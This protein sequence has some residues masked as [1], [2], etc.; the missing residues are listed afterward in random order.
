MLSLRFQLILA[1][2]SPRRKQ[3]LEAL[4]CNFKVQ[5][6]HT[7]EII[8]SHIK[9]TQAAAY[10]AE[11]KALAFQAD[12]E[13]HQAVLAADTIVLANE[14]ILNK[15]ADAQ[16]AAVMLQMLSGNVHQVVTGVCLMTKQHIITHSDI[17]QVHFR[18]LTAQEIDYYI[19][20]YRPFDKAGAYGIQEWIGMI[21]ITKIE[22]SFFTVMGLPTHLVYAMLQQLNDQLPAN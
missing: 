9:A 20:H 1:S 10:L 5:T 2:G 8:P 6:K 11:K 7:D 12:I 18:P 3:L 19:T 22:G 4:G 14:K 15:P 16:Q 21:G 13:A 17:A